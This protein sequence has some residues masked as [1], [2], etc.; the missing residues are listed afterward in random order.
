MVKAAKDANA[1]D[2]IME[3]DEGYE[4]RIGEKGVMRRRRV[5]LM[6]YKGGSGRIL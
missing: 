5:S 4:T 3:L 6:N 1:H 2:F